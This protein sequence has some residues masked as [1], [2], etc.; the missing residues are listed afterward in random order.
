MIQKRLR[1]NEGKKEP[2]LAFIKTK[3]GEYLKKLQLFTEMWLKLLVKTFKHLP[4]WSVR[5]LLPSYWARYSRGCSSFI[6][7]VLVQVISIT[8]IL[9][10]HPFLLIFFFF[11]LK[12]DTKL[13]HLGIVIMTTDADIAEGRSR[14]GSRKMWPSLTWP[15]TPVWQLMQSLPEE[16][17]SLDETNP[18]L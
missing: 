8:Q 9:C 18:G 16:N 6:C 11:P 4:E 7:V 5:C 3:I 12:G 17:Q 1:S 15:W 10:Y 13:Y 14:T 2:S